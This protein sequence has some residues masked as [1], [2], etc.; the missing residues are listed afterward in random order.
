VLIVAEGDFEDHSI[1]D[2]VEI[3]TEFYRSDSFQGGEVIEF[4][5]GNVQ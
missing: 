2:D 1:F 5:V 3:E 4:E